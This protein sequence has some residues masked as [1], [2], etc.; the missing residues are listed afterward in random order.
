MKLEVKTASTDALDAVKGKTG[1]V[2]P[3]ICEHRLPRR[4]RPLR[5]DHL[6]GGLPR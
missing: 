4:W 1:R 6:P 2:C 5:E 3:L